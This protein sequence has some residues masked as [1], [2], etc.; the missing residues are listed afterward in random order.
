LP[1]LY[2]DIAEDGIIL[3]DPQ[4]YAQEKLTYLRELI[5]KKGLL[6]EK[7][8]RDF[9]WR[10]KEFPGFGWSLSWSEA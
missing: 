3:Y 5:R 8:G 7:I 1:A 10:W 2:L 6:R 4:G 9:A